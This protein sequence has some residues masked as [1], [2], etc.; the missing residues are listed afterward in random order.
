M[1]LYKLYNSKAQ[2]QSEAPLNTT[3]VE[4]RGKFIITNKESRHEAAHKNTA[5]PIRTR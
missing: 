4:Y 2:A 1:K 5:R 3:V